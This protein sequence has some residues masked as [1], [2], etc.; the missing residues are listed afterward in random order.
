[1][2]TSL[3]PDPSALTRLSAYLLATR[4]TTSPPIPFPGCPSAAD[5]DILY[6]SVKRTN[7]MSPEDI[8]VLRDLHNDLV[9]ICTRGRE[10]G[11]KVIIDAE[12]RFV[13]LHTYISRKC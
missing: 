10:R 1:M 2:Q 4:P 3:V 8:A 9:R 7:P 6:K 13:M 12:Y 11:V 5:L